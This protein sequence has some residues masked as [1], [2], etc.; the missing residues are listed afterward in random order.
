MFH[1]QDNQ[2]NVPDGGRIL[3]IQMQDL[4]YLNESFLRGA[5]KFG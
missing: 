3:A 1:R 5:Q 2:E 4:R